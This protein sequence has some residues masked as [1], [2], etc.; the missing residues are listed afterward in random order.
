MSL[1]AHE[2]WAM[3]PAP[4]GALEVG[5]P[6]PQLPGA[7]CRGEAPKDRRAQ[8]QQ[9]LGSLALRLKIPREGCHGVS[10]VGSWRSQQVQGACKQ[11]KQQGKSIPTSWRLGLKLQ[12]VLQWDRPW[13]QMA[14][15]PG[16]GLLTSPC[17]RQHQ[18]PG[19]LSRW[20]ATPVLNPQGF[21]QPVLLIVLNVDLWN[22]LWDETEA[23]ISAWAAPRAA[24]QGESSGW[25]VVGRRCEHN[26]LLSLQDTLFT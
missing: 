5:H 12:A 22:V 24:P 20:P 25:A 1:G 8:S 13:D 14:E 15:L 19:R 26:R 2:P 7:L 11:R 6:L 18:A 3:R 21:I 9:A 10:R 16:E 23:H 4:P 17:P